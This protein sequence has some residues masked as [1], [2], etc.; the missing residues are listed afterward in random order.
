MNIKE[1]RVA[2]KEGWAPRKY[3]N[4]CRAEQKSLKYN[5]DPKATVRHHLRDTEE[6]RKYND[7]HY[8]LWGFE[9]DEDG[10]EHFEYGKYMIFITH[11]EHNKLHAVSEETRNARRQT[12]LGDSNK[13]RGRSHSE[14]SKRKMSSKKKGHHVSKETKEKL[15]VAFT[16]EKNPMYGKHLSD[17][18]K[19]NLSIKNSGEGNPMYGKHFSDESKKSISEASKLAWVKIK[20]QYNEYITLG[21]SCSIKEFIKNRKSLTNTCDDQS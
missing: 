12:M 17:E 13:M 9:I 10:N 3:D 6:Q 14:E 1:W 11:E 19:L 8:E 15:S 20:A 4:L 18:E 2:C 16:G 5:P 21:G 7:E